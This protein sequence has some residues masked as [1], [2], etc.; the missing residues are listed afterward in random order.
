MFTETISNLT[1]LPPASPQ[2]LKNLGTPRPKKPKTRVP[3]RPGLRVTD[4]IEE[5]TDL[6]EGLDTFFRPGSTTPTPIVTP[7]SD[8]W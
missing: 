7:D 2:Q 3:T 6:Q 1:E 8:E 5:V 4:V